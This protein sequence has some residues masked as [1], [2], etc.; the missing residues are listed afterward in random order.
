LLVE[1]V[2]RK[3]LL[4]IVMLLVWSAAAF[5]V[6]WWFGGAGQATVQLRAGAVLFDGQGRAYIPVERR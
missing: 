2:T 5:G 6:G 3:W 1:D 4:I